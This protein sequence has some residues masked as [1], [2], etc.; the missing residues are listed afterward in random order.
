VN[1][2]VIFNCDDWVAAYLN[3]NLFSQGHLLQPMEWLVLGQKVG[4]NG[5][6]EIIWLANEQVE[7]AF[8]CKLTEI[9]LE[10]YHK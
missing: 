4:M 8:P 7:D 6:V 9:P 1:H 2:V 10:I 5:R 3:G